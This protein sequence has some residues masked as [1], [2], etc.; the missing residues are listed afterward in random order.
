MHSERGRGSV[1][2]MTEPKLNHGSVVLFRKART[3]CIVG[4]TQLPEAAVI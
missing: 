4:L 3:F 2:K 1:S